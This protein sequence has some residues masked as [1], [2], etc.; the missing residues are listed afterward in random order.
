MPGEPPD[1]VNDFE[2]W[3]RVSSSLQGRNDDECEALIDELGIAD[4]WDRADAAW[5]KALA[6][7][8]CDM[9]LD[10]IG[11]YAEICARTLDARRRKPSVDFR[12]LATYGPT[13]SSPGEKLKSKGTPF[14][15]DPDDR[16][17]TKQYRA[18]A[19]K[20]ALEQALRGDSEDLTRQVRRPGSDKR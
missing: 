19:V 17:P 8:L 15:N 4:V 18:P 5:S 11:R 7:E 20:A 1:V 6:A 12:H 10:R 3:A 14:S 13:G 16:T 2:A 9:K